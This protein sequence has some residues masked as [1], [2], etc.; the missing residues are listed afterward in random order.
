ME[1]GRER[2]NYDLKLL[3]IAILLLCGGLAIVLDAS[4]A[5]AIQS[6]STGYDP[7]FFFKKQAMWSGIAVVVLLGW[8]KIPYWT[9][10]KFWLVGAFASIALLVLV[11]VP[12]IGIEVNGS[13]RWLGFGFMRF[14]PSEFAKIALVLFLARYSDLWR[15]RIKS[16]KKGF[17]PP[18]LVTVALGVLVA[19]EDLGT[20][21]TMVS[22]GLLMIFM[23]GA[24]PKHFAGL[25]GGAAAGGVVFLTLEPYR[26][27]RI[28]GW[29]DL[30]VRPMVPHD[31]VNYQPWQGL[32]A[33]GS[34]GVTGMGLGK[35][36]IAK[37]L[38]LPAEHTDYIFATWGEEAGLIGCLLLLGFFAWLVIRGL[39]VA[40][41]TRDWFGS[42]T[43][44]G[45][46]CMIGI[47]AVLNIGVVT[48]LLPCT[49][50]PLPF[51]SYGG[52]SLLFTGMAIGI[53]LN[54][55]RHPNRTG[56]VMPKE[57]DER[58]NRTDGWRNRRPHLS[59]T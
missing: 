37:H 19:K 29:L 13:R 14:Q 53:I 10:R 8:M 58:E 9:L 46:I 32:V 30:I 21:I 15:S 20:A 39:T 56:G 55:S 11:M 47:Q 52:S 27:E 6:K 35:G 23:M 54:I 3:M 12:G 48:C 17:L 34:G 18:V 31:G 2:E 33:L 28:K 43:A 49:G 50:V 36:G 40:H 51:I 5:R 16:F 7:Y 59:S 57:K 38:Y 42:L 4:F 45:L 26:M 24:Q 25:V 22:T 41:R 1:T 44:A